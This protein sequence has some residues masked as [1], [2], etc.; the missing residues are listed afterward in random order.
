[1]SLKTTIEKIRALETE[2][3]S[4]LIEIEA[5]KK[6]ADAKAN[7]LESEVSALRDEVKSLKMLIEQAEPSPASPNKIK[8]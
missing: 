2:K 3:K 5:L 4:L 7:T 6:M 1:M 8:I